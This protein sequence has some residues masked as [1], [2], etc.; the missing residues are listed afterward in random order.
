MISD[1]VLTITDPVYDP[2]KKPGLLG[3][4][5]LPLIRDERDLPFIRLSLWLTV[6]FIGMATI[7]FWPGM[8]RW[9]MA[10]IYLAV[11]LWYLGPYT[12]MLHNVTHRTLFKKKYNILNK[13]IPWV[14]GPFLGHSPETYAAHHIGIHHAD[15]NLPDDLSTTMPYQRDSLRDFL[16]YYLRFMVSYPQLFRYFITRK[17]Y[18]MLRAFIVGESF[19]IALTAIMLYINWRA[20]LVV[21]VIPFFMT[22]LLLMA[23]NWAQHAFVDPDDPT[24]DYKTVITFINSP[25]NHRCFNDGYHLG[26]HLKANRHWLEMP[27][28]FLNK[29][30]KMIEADSIVFTK[31]DYFIIFLMLMAKQYKLLAKYYVQLDPENPKSEEEIIA[32]FKKRLRAFTPEEL[33]KYSK[34]QPKE[35]KLVPQKS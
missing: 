35:P 9:W 28:D 32:L 2:S 33:A 26:H 16:L 30:Q 18:K 17:R 25:Y 34:Q 31:L 24:D 21:F 8:F 4:L 15:G 10:P 13:F 7:L 3:K 6:L 19:F 12:L 20:A 22:R 11:Y 29:K 27:Q 14:I 1:G 5:F 23:G